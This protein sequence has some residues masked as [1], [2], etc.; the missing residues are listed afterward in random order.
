M[1]DIIVYHFADRA[2]LPRDQIVEQ[3][4]GALAV[5]NVW[6]GRMGLKAFI[7]LYLSLLLAGMP[8]KLLSCIPYGLFGIPT[9]ICIYGL[10]FCRRNCC[11]PCYTV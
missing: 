11:F 3:I 10:V 4:D 1:Q 6:P 2:V 9:V 5:R 7:V 8:I